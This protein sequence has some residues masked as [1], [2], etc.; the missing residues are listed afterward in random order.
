MTRRKLVTNLSTELPGQEYGEQSR[1]DGAVY[2]GHKE[3]LVI[4]PVR[5]AEGWQEK[6]A[7]E[8][9]RTCEG[10]EQERQVPRG[11]EAEAEEGDKHPNVLLV[12]A[13]VKPDTVMVFPRHHHLT[14]PTHLALARAFITEG[15]KVSPQPPGGPDSACEAEHKNKV[16]PPRDQFGKVPE[17]A[18]SLDFVNVEQVE[19]CHSRPV[20]EELGLRFVFDNDSDSEEEEGGEDNSEHDPGEDE[21]E[22][23]HPQQARH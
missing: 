17:Q 8:L 9:A 19:S 6:V 2:P 3:Q 1:D 12:D 23:G 13:E 10:G 11:Q 5:P 20:D 21:V 4:V 22:A 14:H 18:N 15:Q 7:Q 16:F